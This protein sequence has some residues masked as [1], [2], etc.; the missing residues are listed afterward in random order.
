VW[1]EAIAAIVV[2]NEGESLEAAELIQFCKG[3]IAGYKVPKVVHFIPEMPLN[4]TGKISKPELRKQ[5][6]TA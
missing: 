3:K 2:L 6:G 4:S 1:G 5:F